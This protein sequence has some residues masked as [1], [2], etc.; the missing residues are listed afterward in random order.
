MEK[1]IRQ[2]DSLSIKLFTA[3]FQLIFER[4]KWKTKGIKVNGKR[5]SHLRYTDD[6]VLISKSP[7][8]IQEMID[9]LQKESLKIV[10][11]VKRE[12]LKS[13]ATDM[14]LLLGLN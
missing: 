8:Q 6:I 10:L 7:W 5:L 11:K 14:P 13:C 4:L 1:G 12:K 2:D 3:S 9:N